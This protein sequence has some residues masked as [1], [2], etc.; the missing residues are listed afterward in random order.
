MPVVQQMI[1]GFIGMQGQLKRTL[2]L[3]LHAIKYNA[4]VIN[5]LFHQLDTYILVAL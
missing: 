4:M 3:N 2:H 5:I 1:I